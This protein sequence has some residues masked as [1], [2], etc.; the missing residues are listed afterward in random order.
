MVY[1]KACQCF[2]YTK[3]TTK[4]KRPRASHS[5]T[6]PYSS[7]S[8]RI[9]ALSV[10]SVR[11]P[12]K[13]FVGILECRSTRGKNHQTQ[14][15][16]QTIPSQTKSN[17]SEISIINRALIMISASSMHHI[18]IIL[19]LLQAGRPNS[20]VLHRRQPNRFTLEAYATIR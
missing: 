5:T 14:Q 6:S 12:T 8:P 7:N 4:P 10:A 3:L 13:I 17:Q 1:M 18:G 16:L 11:F 19:K 20:Q 9:V 15:I 2:M